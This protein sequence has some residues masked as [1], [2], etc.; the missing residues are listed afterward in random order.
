MTLWWATRIASMAVG[1]GMPTMRFARLAMTS[2]GST[3]PLCQLGPILCDL[4]ASARSFN[5]CSTSTCVRSS[6]PTSQCP[7]NSHRPSEAAVH[8]ATTAQVRTR[9]MGGRAGSRGRVG[10]GGRACDAAHADCNDVLPGVAHEWQLTDCVA[11]EL[12]AQTEHCPE[13][14]AGDGHWRNPTGR[15]AMGVGGR[16]R[17]KRFCTDP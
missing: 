15:E 12:H 8:D 6:K 13:H 11:V 17:R 2:K 14:G 9:S 3:P 5:S 16:R 1:C 7:T 10:G 4:F